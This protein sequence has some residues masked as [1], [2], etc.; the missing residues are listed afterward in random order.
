MNII[1]HNTLK[2]TLSILFLIALFAL[3]MMMHP[4]VHIL[5]D[6]IIPIR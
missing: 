3:L 2:I 5:A 1:L 4:I 6:E